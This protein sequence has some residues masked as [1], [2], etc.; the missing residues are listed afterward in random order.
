MI[1]KRNIG[2]N[3]PDVNLL[4]EIFPRGDSPG[5]SLIGGN[6]PG[7]SFLIPKKI[8]AKNSQVYMH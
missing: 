7:E 2:G 1:I 8:C 4:G 6:F 5:E 3:I